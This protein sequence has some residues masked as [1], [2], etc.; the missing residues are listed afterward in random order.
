MLTASN[1]TELRVC[2]SCGKERECY[3]ERKLD[4]EQALCVY[5]LSTMYCFL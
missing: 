1:D 5:C 4:T 3:V 2:D